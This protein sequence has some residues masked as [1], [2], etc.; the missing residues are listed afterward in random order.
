MQVKGL[1]HPVEVYEVTGAGPTRSRL[2]AAAMRGLT[3]FVGRAAEMETL[4]QALERAAA[5]HGQLVAAMG[6]PGVGKSRLVWEFTRSH[7]TEGW[8]VLESS[9]VSYGKATPYLPVSDLLRGYFQVE[10]ADGPRRRRQKVLG[11]VLDLDEALRPLLPALLTLLDVAVDDAAWQ[12]LEPAERRRQ[13]AE[14]VKRLLWRESQGQPVL[15][16]FEDLHWIDGET[17]VLLDH[18]VESLPTARVL[19]LVSYRPEYQH[20]WAGKTYYTQVRLDPLPPESAEAVLDAL[21]GAGPGLHSLKQLLIARTEGTPFFLEESVRTLAE[22]GALSGERGAYRL[23]RAVPDVQVP[24]TVQA[25]LAARIDRLPPEDK[26]TLQ[27][28]AVIGHE[29]PF[30]LLLAIA[31]GVEDPLRA[32]LARLQAA[33]FLYEAS[34]FPELEYTFKHALTHEVAYGSLLHERRRAL[35][36]QIV[37]AMERLYVDRLGDHVERLAQHAY[38]GEL[39]E[40]AVVYLEQAAAKAAARS[41]HVDAARLLEQALEVQ[42]ALAPDDRTRRCDLLCLLGETLIPAGES[43]RATEQVAREALE[44]AEGLEDERRASRA[45]QIALEGMVR[46]GGA[47]LERSPAFWAW[48]ERADRYAAPGTAERVYADHALAN[49]KVLT[50]EER[51]AWALHRRALA[52]A[53]Q[54]EDPEAQFRSAWKIVMWSDSPRHAEELRPIVAEFVA[55]PREGVNI[56]TLGT[57]LWYA[58]LR[59]LEWGQRERLEGL[60]HE[61]AELGERT[62]D[63]GLLWRPLVLD[64]ILATLDGRLE[65]AREAGARLVARSEERGM[66]ILGLIQARLWTLRP[67]LYLGRFDEALAAANSVVTSVRWSM[68]VFAHLGRRDEAAQALH[69]FLAERDLSSDEDETLAYGLLIALETAVLLG[70]RDL[71]R[72]LTER[73]E[74]LA[75]TLGSRHAGLT[76]VA[77]H[78]GAAA[79]LLGERERAR[80]YYARALDV[81]ARVRFRPEIALTRLQLAELLPDE[82][83]VQGPRYRGGADRRAEALDHLNFAIAEL[84]EMRMQPALERALGHQARLRA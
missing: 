79:A 64:I 70:E 38:R 28:A 61:I 2:H 72:P 49:Y 73:L 24:A 8:L 59:Y 44:L 18:L 17:Q 42:Q 52:L 51:E 50:G 37:E 22:S 41:A 81:A 46:Y 58:G 84:R 5:G 25:V 23:D 27:S 69:E 65:E 21:L 26:R 19:L 55:R 62:R 29:L 71:V 35:H 4:R 75:S 53:R 83:A 1:A 7:H 3:R 47:Q 43:Q 36:A 30:P 12:R 11:K 40:K 67:L 80:G 56:R 66:A 6:E 13:T 48:A 9:S 15:L 33:E 54:L 78:L 60:T 31:E 10:P 68:L 39:R 76:C 82:V 57:F 74:P 14:A 63:V 16:L 32:S 34:L 77:R 20:R 45:C